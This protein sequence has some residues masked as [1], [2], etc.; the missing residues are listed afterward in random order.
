MMLILWIQR[1]WRCYQ[2]LYI[3]IWVQILY[4]Q[5]VSQSWNYN[6][7]SR[8]FA[9]IRFS[10]LTKSFFGLEK[11]TPLILLR[12]LNQVKGLCYGTRL[13]IIKMGDKVLEQKVIIGSNIGDFVLIPHITLTPQTSH[14]PFPM[15]WRQFSIKLAFTMTIYKSQNHRRMLLCIFL[16]LYFLMV[17]WILHCPV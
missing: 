12:N 3:T 5:L 16:I 6:E 11:G 13:P 17:N 9:F 8:V 15:K 1:Y 4:T 10:N 7:S 2:K 14:S